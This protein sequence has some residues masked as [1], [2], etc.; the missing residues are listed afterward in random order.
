MARNERSAGFICFRRRTD[1]SPDAA[2]GV[3]YLLLDYGRH[4]EYAKGHV[5]KGEGDLD[6]ALRELREE[7]GIAD[8]RVIDG[9]RNEV[10]YFFRDRRKG[11]I[12]KTVV[13]FLAE[14]RTADA[15]VVLSHEHAGFVFLPLEAA[16]KRVTF[17]GARQVLRAA[18]DHLVKIGEATP[19][20][21]GPSDLFGRSPTDRTE[22]AP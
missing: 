21:P 12:R 9:F 10:I 4:W 20:P 19:C 18:H 7:T 8:A 13:F 16:L 15:D 5:E 3:E 2:D 14:T 1:R 6:A 22:P 11:L 17:A